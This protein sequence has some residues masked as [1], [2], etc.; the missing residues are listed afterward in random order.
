[1]VGSLRGRSALARNTPKK[2]ASGVGA[3]FLFYMAIRQA[4]TASEVALTGNRQADIAGRRHL[5]DTF[6]K[7]VE[8][9]S[10][11]KM[12]LRLGG[13]YT[14]ERLAGEVLDSPRDADRNLYW[15][16]METLTAFVRE[17]TR[18]TGRA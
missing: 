14:L 17:R 3:L 7:A 4:R 11:D 16:V 5:T 6:S 10:S 9:L 18:R 8:Q 12:E 2:L 1:M 13:L 15:T